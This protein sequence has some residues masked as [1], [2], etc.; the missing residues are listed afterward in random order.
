MARLGIQLPVIEKVLNHS[1]GSFRGIVGVYQRHS[2]ADEK[3]QALQAWANFVRSAVS[4]NG[5]V[6]VVALR[7]AG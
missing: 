5:P 7:G 1:S 3:R 2:Y 4:D 6:N